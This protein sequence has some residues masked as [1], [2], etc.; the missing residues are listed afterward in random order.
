MGLKST[1]NRAVY[2]CLWGL[3]ILVLVLTICL[4]L[5]VPDVTIHHLAEAGMEHRHCEVGVKVTASPV[6]AS[7][8]SVAPFGHLMDL[9]KFPHDPLRFFLLQ[10]DTWKK[11][12]FMYDSYI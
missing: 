2:P 5:K 1:A 8:L 6:D 9:L 12:M 4:T 10:F 7:S 3:A 11:Y